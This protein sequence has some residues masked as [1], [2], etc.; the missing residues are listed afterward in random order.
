MEALG[1]I[2]ILAATLREA[3]AGDLAA[4]TVALC[5]LPPSP[6]LPTTPRLPV[7]LLVLPSSPPGGHFLFEAPVGDWRPRRAAAK[8]FTGK[9]LCKKRKIGVSAKTGESPEAFDKKRSDKVCFFKYFGRCT[10]VGR[11]VTNRSKHSTKMNL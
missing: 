5:P 11:K 6:R 9:S 8:N 10:D 4:R 2:H 7:R 1:K 3:P